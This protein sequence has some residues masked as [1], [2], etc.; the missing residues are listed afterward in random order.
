MGTTIAKSFYLQFLYDSLCTC[1]ITEDAEGNILGC[2]TA[3]VVPQDTIGPE[4]DGHILTLA[5][6]PL[7]RRKGIGRDI[8]EVQ[9]SQSRTNVKG[10][11][12][13]IR[14]M[15]ARLSS[16]KG[17]N[18]VLKSVILHTSTRNLVALKFYEE[19]GY[20]RLALKAGYYGAVNIVSINEY[21]W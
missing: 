12:F 16:H 14:A 4:R 3:K 13:Q 17:Q 6:E 10:L 7:W 21:L 15:C 20:K 1:I 19:C 18:V 9:L 8:L 2:G 5:V 11:V